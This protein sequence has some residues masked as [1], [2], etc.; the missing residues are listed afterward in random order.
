M[1]HASVALVY[2]GKDIT[3]NIQPL[4]QG[5]QYDE[6]AEGQAD[7]LSITLENRDLRWLNAW[8]PQPGDQIQSKLTSYDWNSPGEALTLDCGTMQVDSPGFGGPPDTVTLKALQIPANEGFS[9]A[10]QDTTWNSITMSQLGK[11]IADRYGLAFEYDAPADFTIRALK[12]TKQTDSD[13]L[14]NTAQKYNLCLKVYS[15][16]LV[17]YSKMLYEQRD[18][19][20]TITYGSSSIN[21]YSLDSP[22]VG[23]RFDAVTILYKPVKSKVLNSYTYPPGITKGKIMRLQVA[24][25]DDSQAEMVAQGKLRE[26]NEK[27]FTGT[28]NL[29]LNLDIVAACTVML[30]GFGAF[31][32]KHFIDSC[33]HKYGGSAGT[34]SIKAHKC[35]SGG[36]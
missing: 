3:A 25:D 31:D 5:F 11:E 12:R 28:F 16:K 8:F 1:R 2:E 23:T 13:L 30:K 18:P 27:A 26:A 24:V 36:Y 22:L 21:S 9:D 33:S 7:S 4:L 35:L 34:T 20:A 32:G 17:I 6:A 14:S 15:N 29:A 10:P 19:V